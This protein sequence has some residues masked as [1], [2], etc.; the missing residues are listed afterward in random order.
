MCFGNKQ[1]I[2]QRSICQVLNNAFFPFVKYDKLSRMV[3]DFQPY[4][5]LWTTAS[6]WIRWSESWMN[7]PLSA[8]EAEQLEKSVNESFKTMHK[9]VKQFKDVPGSYKVWDGICLCSLKHMK[10][11]IMKT[12]WL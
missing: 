6:D 9:C 11:V 4:W 10:M 12:S 5:D 8:I 2:V 1:A 7:D 3:K